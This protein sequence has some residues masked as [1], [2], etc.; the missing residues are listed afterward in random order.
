ML[1]PVHIPFH[2][3]KN[4]KLIVGV[5]LSISLSVKVVITGPFLSFQLLAKLYNVELDRFKLVS[6]VSDLVPI[7]TLLV[8]LLPFV[9]VALLEHASGWL[10]QPFKLLLLSNFVFFKPL[11][12]LIEQ[13]LRPFLDR[14]DC[15]SVKVFAGPGRRAVTFRQI[16][17]LVKTAELGICIIFLQKVG[18]S[19]KSKRDLLQLSMAVVKL[20]LML[21]VQN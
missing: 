15:L 14:D 4:N 6:Q 2:V 20:V 10:L 9:E 12:N 17:P 21:L 18:R 19:L 8:H 5:Q 1:K 11:L 7:P 13:L 3:L 16:S